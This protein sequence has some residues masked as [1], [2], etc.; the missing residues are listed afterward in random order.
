MLELLAQGLAVKEIADNLD[1]A[2]RTV[3][4]HLTKIY[5]KL[6]VP[7]QTGAVAKALRAGII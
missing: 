5:E 7:S 6:Q 1:I 4:Y 2:I 3:G